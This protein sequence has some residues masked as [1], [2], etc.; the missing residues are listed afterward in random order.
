M[1]QHSRWSYCFGILLSLG[2]SLSAWAQQGIGTQK[3]VKSAALEIRSQSR[4]ILIPRVNLEDLNSFSPPISGPEA[5]SLLVYNDT[6]ISTQHIYP[7][8]Y[9]WSAIAHAWRPLVDTTDVLIDFNN[10]SGIYKH[11]A[12]DGTPTMIDSTH[13]NLTIFDDAYADLGVLTVQ[14]AI[15]SLAD[16][17]FGIGSDSLNVQNGLAVHTALNGIKDS[18]RL[19]RRGV[20]TPT[21]TNAQA[22]DLYID[23]TTGNVFYYN[24]TL[25]RSSNNWQ[26]QGDVVDGDDFIGTLNNQALRFKQNNQP[27]GYID[28]GLTAFGRGA[29]EMNSTGEYNTAIGYKAMSLNTEGKRNTA[30]GWKAMSKNEDGKKNVA[31]GWEALATNVHGDENVAIGYEALDEMDG[32]ARRNIGIGS[33]VDIRDNVDYS[34]AIGYNA[35]AGNTAKTLQNAIAFGARAKVEESYSLVLGSI[36][37]VNY[38]DSTIRVGIGTTTPNHRLEVVGNLQISENRHN[39]TGSFSFRPDTTA[40]NLYFDG[41]KIGAFDAHTGAYTSV[42]DGR[43]KE[44]IRLAG[45]LLK[46][47]NR[48]KVIR[49]VWKDDSDESLQIGFVAQQLYQQ[50]P[51]FVK[52]PLDEETGYYTVNYA[53][54]SAVAIKAIQE[55]QQQISILQ[56]KLFTLQKKLAKEQHKNMRQFKKLKELQA[57]L[58][59]MLSRLA[60]LEE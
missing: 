10:A 39:T 57:A 47:V 45:T 27:A 49:Y 5:H 33:A 20:G 35:Y 2:M 8:F 26:L 29:L 41:G 15:D 12:V 56:H 30:V 24:D 40:L 51:E 25:W 54:M 6:T 11:I 21:D 58:K 44:K 1:P 43:L 52:P 31:L 4:G 19:V 55:Q 60:V 13:A 3:P 14:S 59:D 37:G 36:K 32:N 46:K 17:L 22:G 28:G 50:F 23:Y 9:Y 16:A 7:G 34:I 38:A 18:I 42:S 53:G 48:V